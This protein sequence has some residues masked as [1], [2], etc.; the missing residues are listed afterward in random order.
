MPLRSSVSFTGL[1]RLFTGITNM[2][3]FAQSALHDMT[4]ALGTELLQAYKDNLNGV[5]AST[6]DDPL[7]VGVRTG[8]LLAGAQLEAN[9]GQAV[10]Q[11]A[12][13]I[14][15][16][17]P[18]AGF[19]EDGTVKMAPRRPLGAA[20]DKMADRFG[21]AVGQAMTKIVG[22]V[23]GTDDSTQVIGDE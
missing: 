6:A 2:P 9:A 10:N 14:V 22:S 12:F 5:V 21:A 20:I 18:W 16:N 3:A 11:H 19:I 23:A 13:R 8:E 4:E 1:T 17:T 15:N 7:P